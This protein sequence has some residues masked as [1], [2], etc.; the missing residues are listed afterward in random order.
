MSRDN[1]TDEEMGLCDKHGHY[2]DDDPDTPEPE[3]HDHS[4][5]FD[6]DDLIPH[7]R[8]RDSWGKHEEP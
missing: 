1:P 3:P 5:D 7:K 4:D 6:E 2:Y 8:I